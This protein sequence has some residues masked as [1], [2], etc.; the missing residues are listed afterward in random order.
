MPRASGSGSAVLSIECVKWSLSNGR[1]LR[2]QPL[3]NVTSVE[4]ELGT[5]SI[6]PI[7]LASALVT[8]L[9]CA[10]AITRTSGRVRAGW[11]LLAVSA[12]FWAAGTAAP[13]AAGSDLAFLASVPF[14]FG[15]MR[16]FWVPVPG[17]PPAGRVWLD[18]TIVALALT[19]V[20]WVLGLRD[21]VSATTT[22]AAPKLLDVAAHV[23]AIV[24]AT[25]V[26][27][28]ARRATRRRAARVFTLL[29]GV[30]TLALAHGAAEY[31]A[32]GGR[33]EIA[34][35]AFAG[36]ALISIAAVWPRSAVKQPT[37]STTV[38]LWQLALP[39]IAV[40]GIGLT[41]I[42]V[43]VSGRTL[44]PVLTLIV[45]VTVVL[46]A[47]SMIF[48]N[49]DFLKMLR[50]SQR[51]EATLAEVVDRAPLA[52]ARSDIQLRIIGANPRLA[53]LVS[54]RPESM[55]GI[56]LAKY[57]PVEAQSEMFQKLG[58]LGAGKV[59]T[60]EGEVP[61][62]RADG[63]RA[64]ARWTST[65]VRNEQGQTAYYLTVLEDIDA[66]HEAE[67]A[68]R[69]SLVT[70]ERLNRLK[71]EFLQSVSHEFKTALI[72]IQGF[73]EFMRDSDELQ[74]QDVRG[75][76]DD[77]H[78]DAERLDRMVSEMIAL[79][80]VET[81]RANLRFASVDLNDVIRR[82]VARMPAHASPQLVV[83]LQPNLEP[84]SGDEAK[85]GEV[86][87]TLLGNA[88]QY[89]PEGGHITLTS[90]AEGG[91][92]TVTIVD[93]G[94]GMRSDFD[95]RLFGQDDLYANNPIRKVVGTGLGLGIARQII[96]MHGGRLWVDRIEGKGS[97]FHF[98]IPVVQSSIILPA[99]GE[100]ARVA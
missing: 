57:I 20:A 76:A 84:V 77:I 41:S 69:Q 37:K 85:L 24:I 95:N 33:V 63:S 82:E 17:D 99:A 93:E 25:I 97:Q 96:E 5:W 67:E 51:S 26:I 70:L 32:L 42:G 1:G 55:L 88:A 27:L 8:A 90:R 4:R 36:Y 11:I 54:E 91:Q 9:A 46:L 59:E 73:S 6:Y 64:W 18:G 19:F 66:R 10:W 86:V 75:F 79:D 52:I 78:R 48:T 60:A 71:G 13:T 94:V 2:W 80:N 98:S 30:M 56:T 39:W 28:A 21:L 62:V 61:L 89:S 58:D 15:S 12:A 29:V 14:T 16:S 38:D 43:F 31:L 50:A 74:I 23:G 87:G 53:A 34:A 44:D 49:R 40:L 72:G 7:L 100:G 83:D 81:A 92:V 22:T 68:A 35:D 45:G 3:P 47:V 65:A